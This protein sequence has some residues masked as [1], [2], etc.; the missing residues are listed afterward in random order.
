MAY[1]A[2]LSPSSAHR[3]TECTASIDAQ[4]GIPNENSDASR[5]GTTCHQMQ[6]E[7]LENQ[8]VQ[9]Q[10]YLGRT[11]VFWKDMASSVTGESW[12]DDTSVLWDCVEVE[13]EVV[14]DQS[15]L[16]AVDA[17]MEF[18]LGY[19]LL[20][21]G[22]L[23]VEQRVP[24]GHFTGEEGATGSADVIIVGDTWVTVMDSKFGRHKVFAFEAA[25]VSPVD[26][27]L[28]GL[29]DRME[30]TPNLQMACYAIGTLE[31]LRQRGIDISKIKTVTMMILQPFV[32][33][34]SD[35][36]MTA[37]DLLKVRD[38][39]A[40]KAEETRTNPVFKPTKDNCHFCLAAGPTCAA[41]TEMVLSTVLDGFED[42]DTA[43]VKPLPENKLGSLYDVV[44]AIEQW[45]TQVVAR[46][47]KTLLDGGEV[48]RNDGL[49]YKLVEGKSLPRNWTDPAKVR[50]LLLAGALTENEIETTTLITPAQAEAFSKTKRA[51]KGEPKVPPA[52]PAEKWSVL[53]G[54]MTGGKG[55]PS[56]VLETDPRP[57]LAKADGFED[58]P[59]TPDDGSDL[60]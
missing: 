29:D 52:I 18:V 24:V 33:H 8:D 5:N 20:H 17:A 43:T 12:K 19:Q 53:Q 27:L 26:I 47:R 25:A 59:D 37:E 32:H 39:L 60:F 45:C 58:I 7:C 34:T 44:P 22:D 2:K 6:A 55:Q 48:V 50:P 11:L 57:A 3:W 31:L 41:Q 23:W 1:H 35:F 16:N 36:T 40:Q 46:V 54:Y 49:Q 21:G 10:S 15:M 42:V 13:A 56:V 4:A 28:G 38:F 9:L 51:K 30:F 14:V